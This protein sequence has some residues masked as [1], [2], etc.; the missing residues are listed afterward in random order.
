ML[1]LPIIA[2]ALFASASAFARSPYQDSGSY[3]GG[4]ANLYYADRGKAPVNDRQANWAACTRLYPSFNANTG[5]FM[6]RDGL[7]HAC[8]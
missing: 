3:A 1:R 7:T 2:L 5:T 8:Q 6:G 4:P